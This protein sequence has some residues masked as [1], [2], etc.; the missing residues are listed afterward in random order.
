MTILFLFIVEVKKKLGIYAQNC[1]PLT[2][3]CFWLF[4]FFPFLVIL[5]AAIVYLADDN[6]GYA[7]IIG[8]AIAGLAILF[9]IGVS[10]GAIV[11]NEVFKV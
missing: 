4:I 11:L 1:L 7:N 8:T 2:I 6:Q 3:C 10:I 5:P 9:M